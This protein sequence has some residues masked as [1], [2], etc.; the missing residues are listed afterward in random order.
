MQIEITNNWLIVPDGD[1]ISANIKSLLSFYEKSRK[2]NTNRGQITIPPKISYAYAIVDNKIYIPVGL[3]PL[4]SDCFTLDVEILD[5]RNCSNPKLLDVNACIENID[6]YENILPGIT[7][8][9]HQLLAIRKILYHKRGII[10]SC[11][12]CFTGDT[13]VPLTDGTVRRFDELINNYSGKCVYTSR[14]DG[15]VDVSRIKSVHITRWTTELIKITLDDGSVVKCTNNHPFMLRNG[16]YKEAGLLQSGDSLMPYTCVLSSRLD[17]CIVSNTF[18]S[19]SGRYYRGKVASHKLV[20]KKFVGDVPKGYHIHHK[21]KNHFNDDIDNLDILSRRD[22]IRVH[23]KDSELQARRGRNNRI[24]NYDHMKLVATK[25]IVSYNKS[26]K[27]RAESRNRAIHMRDLQKVYKHENPEL[28]HIKRSLA[29]MKSNCT[30]YHNNYPANCE[31]CKEKFNTLFLKAQDIDPNFESWNHKVELVEYI[32]LEEP[33]PV[34]DLEVD[35]DEHNF[36]IQTTFKNDKYEFVGSGIYVHNSGK[37]EMMIATI[38]ILTQLNDGICPTV[39]VFEPTTKLITDTVKRFKQYDVDAVAYSKNRKIL[40]NT[41]NIAHPK[42]LG[43]DLKENPKLLEGVEVLF[44]DE[45]HHYTCETYR[46]P[47]YDMP[48]LLYSIGVSA[49]AISQEHVGKKKI[50]Q[51]SY[52]EVLTMGATG[53]LLINITSEYLIAKGDLA[54]PI[55]FRVKYEATEHLNKLFETDWNRV[56]KVHLQSDRRNH[57]ICRLAENFAKV[58]RKVLILVNTVEWSRKLLEMFSAMG[59]YNLVFAS[60][61]GGKLEKVTNEWHPQ[62]ISGESDCFDRFDSGEYKILIGTT[63]LYEGADIKNLDVII[64]AY[65]GNAERLQVQGL[66]RALRKTKTG[67]YAYV[68]DFTDDNDLVL[69]KHSKTRLKRYRDIIGIPKDNIYDCVDESKVDAIF[70][71]REGL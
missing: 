43:N 34:Y 27:G 6:A 22:H 68:I 60:Y 51:Y 36:A 39:L 69:S 56:S 49:S 50:N 25:S 67:K 3:Y 1:L 31:V 48:S 54:N 28:F 65:G 57:L 29:T 15:S 70:R 52:N 5:H 19:K 4:L 47:T 64:L 58:G 38:K 9:R 7:L 63:H 13:K 30:R 2:V 37:T 10:N 24:A 14:K 71:D 20:C 40:P 33:I 55:L 32:T 61:G 12:G 62:F 8:K 16:E 21:D 59:D 46:I 44:G 53:A 41:V 17:K 26:E 18:C 23:N 35:N 42:S 45:C 11:T 66:G